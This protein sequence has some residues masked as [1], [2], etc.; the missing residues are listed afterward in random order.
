MLCV[1][2][3]SALDFMCTRVLAHYT[4]VRMRIF[5]SHLVQ[6]THSQE[7]FPLNPLFMCHSSPIILTHPTLPFA[8]TTHT[9]TVHVG[10]HVRTQHHT[11][12]T[13]VRLFIH[14]V[15]DLLPRVH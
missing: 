1:C 8:N 5:P 10:I 9:R 2:G 3:T 12:D 6:L 4:H 11:H 7:H 15:G 13:Y 14:F